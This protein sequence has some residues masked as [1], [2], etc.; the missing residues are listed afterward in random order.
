MAIAA[1]DLATRCQLREMLA[2]RA[3]GRLEQAILDGEPPVASSRVSGKAARR[4][5]RGDL[6]AILAKALRRNPSQR[7]LTAEALGDDIERHLGSERVLARPDGAWY[8]LRKAAW[9]HRVGF[10]A[11]A[12]ALVA[13]VAGS[14]MAVLQAQRASRASEPQQLVTDYVAD[15]FR[16]NAVSGSDPATGGAEG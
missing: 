6:D 1:A 4:A 11:A 16:I 2:T 15:V 12:V 8:G 14:A 9:R 13:I 10:S 5:L 3:D 7:Y